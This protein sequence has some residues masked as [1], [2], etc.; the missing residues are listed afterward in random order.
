M[1]FR[2][3]TVEILKTL[4][5]EDERL[6]LNKILESIRL[7]RIE[8]PFIANASN[9]GVPQNRERVLFIGCRKD[10]KF[11]SEIPPTVKENEKVTVFEALYDLDFIGNNQEAHHYELVDISK[12]F[13]S[14][15]QKMK[16]FIKKR[17][18]DGKINLQEG[19]TFSEWS[20]EG[21]LIERFRPKT[22][23]FYVKD[24][25]GLSNG[26]KYFDILNNHKTSNQNEDVIKRLQIILN[27][28]DYKIAQCELED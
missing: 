25:N 9:Y 8:K 24:F 21:R 11:I 14:T 5:T 17:T 1:L 26:E 19:K 3:E 13:N 10:Q 2:S 22:K 27:Q 28:G 20:R 12:Q 6:K 4:C 23:P 16:S 15:A 7:Y 18:V